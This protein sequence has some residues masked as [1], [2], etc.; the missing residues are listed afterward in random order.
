M[1]LQVL[2]AAHIPLIV[3]VERVNNVVF[4]FF[5]YI[6]HIVLCRENSECKQSDLPKGNGNRS[7]LARKIKSGKTEKRKTEKVIVGPR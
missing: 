5:S 1:S 4:F 2:F 3:P 7:H 6:L